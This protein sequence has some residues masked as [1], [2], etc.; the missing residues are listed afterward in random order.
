MPGTVKNLVRHAGR[1]PTRGREEPVNEEQMG[2]AEGL[3]QSISTQGQGTGKI[4]AHRGDQVVNDMGF[5]ET[6]YNSRD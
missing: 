6:R 2:Q 1:D 5:K 3:V 4:P